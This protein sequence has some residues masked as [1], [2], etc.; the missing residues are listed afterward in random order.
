MTDYVRDAAVAA[1]IFGF[2]GSTWFGWAQE[3]PPR[4]WRRWLLGGAVLCLAVLIVG[5]ILAVRHW[6]N[7]TAFDRD[8]SIAFGIVVGI[9]FAL[10]GIGAAILG[11]RGRKELIPVW[12]AL[13]VGVHFFP[14]AAIID[15]SL[16]YVVGAL[17]TL[18]ALAAVPLARARSV[19][20]SAVNG[21]LVGTA[22]LASAL[23]SLGFAL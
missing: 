1:A 14:L 20:V 19:D 9:E 3:S 12:I 5:V 23:V 18:G 22:L 2:F 21:V 11:S 7:G 16:M 17:V 15:Y 8:T 4:S 10:A 6:D 13:V